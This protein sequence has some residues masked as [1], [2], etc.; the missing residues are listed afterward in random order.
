MRMRVATYARLRG[1]YPETIRHAIRTGV[2]R[3][4]E[5]D[6]IDSDQADDTWH[7]QHQARLE[8]R[9]R[10]AE[11]SNTALQVQL[12]ARLSKVQ[13]AKTRHEARERDYIERKEVLAAAL[14]G[15][16]QIGTLRSLLAEQE[17]VLVAEIKFDEPG[18]A[19]LLLDEVMELIIAELGDIEA[20]ARLAA[21]QL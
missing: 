2:I 8:A 3:Q 6:A 13:L 11:Q 18:L 4:F 12:A 14:A 17:P 16:A 9:A 5:N 21:E 10:G 7:V 19:T 15:V 20:E 1:V